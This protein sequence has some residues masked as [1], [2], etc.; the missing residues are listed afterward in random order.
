MKRKTIPRRRM[1]RVSP[2]PARVPPRL[3]RAHPQLARAHP[4]RVRL[5]P[6]CRLSGAPGRLGLVLLCP[7]GAIQL[8]DVAAAVL[9]LC[10]GR[11]TREQIVARMLAASRR[12]LDR[13]VREF[14]AAAYRQGWLADSA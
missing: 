9:A 5:A 12:S 2:R 10:D 8:N 6:G 7:A 3:G 1:P 11:L 13:N 4:R 14:L